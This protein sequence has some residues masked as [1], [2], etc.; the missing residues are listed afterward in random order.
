M[1]TFINCK[2]CAFPRAIQ[3][4]TQL[5]KDTPATYSICP[6]HNCLVKTDKDNG[7]SRGKLKDT[8]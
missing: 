7:C 3:T 4:I 8:P 5:I 2:E 6:V 1:V